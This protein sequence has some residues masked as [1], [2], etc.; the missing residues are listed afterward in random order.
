[1]EKETLKQQMDFCEQGQMVC[2]SCEQTINVENFSDHDKSLEHKHN[3]SK[4]VEKM[5]N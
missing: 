5:M 4:K 1:M 3:V 2:L